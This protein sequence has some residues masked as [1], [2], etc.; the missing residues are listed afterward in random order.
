MLG[1]WT[2]M[3]YHASLWNIN[4]AENTAK[5]D[6]TEGFSTKW[7]RRISRGLNTCKLCDDDDDDDELQSSS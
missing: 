5:D 2:E 6:P 1:E 7:D 3:D 4:H